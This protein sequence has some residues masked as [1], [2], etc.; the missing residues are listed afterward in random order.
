MLN[1]VVAMVE[2]TYQLVTGVEKVLA[3]AVE[4]RLK[5]EDKIANLEEQA[6]RVLHVDIVGQDG[7]AMGRSDRSG[8]VDARGPYQLGHNRTL[9]AGR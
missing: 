8:A 2:S 3:T 7:Q 6:H 1:N 4:R 5:D 9:L